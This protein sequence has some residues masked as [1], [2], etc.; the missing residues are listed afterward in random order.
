MEAGTGVFYEAV[1]AALST[2]DR[3]ILN[4]G[5]LHPLP[6]QFRT[7]SRLGTILTFWALPVTLIR[8]CE[9]EELQ[10]GGS[11]PGEK[12][13]Q[14]LNQHC[15]LPVTVATYFEFLLLAADAC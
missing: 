4:G 13:D 12:G 6:A 3:R 1:F 11:F 15:I 9:R 5:G 8:R 14:P 7:S 10:P 2:D